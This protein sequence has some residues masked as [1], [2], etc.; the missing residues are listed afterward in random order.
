MSDYI[1]HDDND[2]GIDRRGFL[3][4]MAGAGTGAFC[5]VKGGVVKSFALNQLGR[6][7]VGSLKGERNPEEPLPLACAYSPPFDHA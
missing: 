7:D 5:V 6:H 2:D 1:I 3:K 4:C